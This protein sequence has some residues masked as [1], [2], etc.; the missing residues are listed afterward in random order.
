M[1]TVAGWIGMAKSIEVIYINGVF[2]PSEPLEL[3]LEEGQRLTFILPENG[4]D[5]E[6]LIEDEDLRK[7]CAAQAGEQVPSLEDVRQI[8][9][10]IPGSM[11]D[12]VISERDERF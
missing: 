3:E 11:A 4:S 8:L 10:Q 5:L 1:N 7:W 6:Q 2:R 9:S 12:V